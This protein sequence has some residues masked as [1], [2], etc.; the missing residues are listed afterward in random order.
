MK[1]T[2]LVE[3][4]TKCELK[5]KHGLSLYIQ[6][7]RHNILFDLGSDNTL[8][9]NA[10]I[11]D[12]NLSNIDI[13]IISHG[14]IDHGGSLNRF[15]KINSKA[16]LYVQRTAFEP[17][18]SKM[19]FINIS[20]GL[21]KNIK[22]HPQIILVDG[23]YQIDEELSLFSVS[24]TDKC[25]SSANH[26]LYD[27][28]GRDSFLHEH[29][30]IIKENKVTLIMG[31]GH[32]GIV[33]IMKKAQA[34]QPKICVGGF[35]LFNPLTK[36]TVPTTVLKDISKELLVY[37]QTQFYTCHCTGTKAFQYLSQQ[38]PNLSYLSCG[39]EIEI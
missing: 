26:A 38:L 19:F 14:H 31:C 22:A 10:K 15:L 23:D 25:Y 1:I 17:H 16:K 34:Y 21:D 18:F 2:A 28:K 3:N 33:N 7:Q 29:N 13:V 6:T 36:K 32:C 30:L 24:E 4:Q 12:I 20:I 8:F 5:A 27:S 39:E 37:S 11:R 9:E 35:H